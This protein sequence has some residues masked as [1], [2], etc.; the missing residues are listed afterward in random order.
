MKNDIKHIGWPL[1]TEIFHPHS[2]FAMPKDEAVCELL[3]I[4]LTC[5]SCGKLI[6]RN[7]TE[8]K[9]INPPVKRYWMK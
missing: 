4:N 3:N 2:C 9:Q 5:Y 8:K 6:K 7:P 1:P